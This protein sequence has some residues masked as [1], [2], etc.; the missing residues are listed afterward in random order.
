[1][2]SDRFGTEPESFVHRTHQGISGIARCRDVLDEYGSRLVLTIDWRTL[3][4]QAGTLRCL[5]IDIDG[6]EGP[7]LASGRTSASS[8]RTGSLHAPE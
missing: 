7:F 2:A 6:D 4:A 5:K 8:G 3:L 1:M